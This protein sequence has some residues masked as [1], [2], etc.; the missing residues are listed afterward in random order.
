MSPSTSP[1]EPDGT[2][3]LPPVSV[4]L[5]VREEERHLTAAIEQV[6]DQDY[7]GELEIVVA[8]GPSHDRTREIAD[9]LAAG[10]AR[11]RVLDNP[12]GLTPAGLNIAVAAARHDVLV[13]VD[14][15]SEIE[16]DYVRVAVEALLE[17]GAANVGGLMV[18]V[19][20][21]PFEEAVARAMSSRLGIGAASFHTGGQA[22]PAPTVYLGVFRR[23]ALE[24]VGGYD[25]HFVRAQD[26]ELNHRLR[27][28]GDVVWFDP[29]LAVTYRPRGDVRSLAR[30]FFRSGQWRRQV[31][32]HHP[33]TAGVRYLT[34]PAAVVGIAG[35]AVL[36]LVGATVGPTWLVAGAVVPAAYAVGV[37]AGSVVVGR[38]MSPAARLRLP[39]AIATMHVAWGSGFLRGVGA[40][41][42]GTQ[43]RVLYPDP[44]N[45]SRQP[46]SA[47]GEGIDRHPAED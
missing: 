6:L 30:Q 2:S 34:P 27:E 36:G 37:L 44:A 32:R 35:G 15:H 8:V 3:S 10:D 39:A 5:T 14:G 23:D 20:T 18:P 17:T 46:R 38:G 13:R 33:E 26:W 11:V 25:E 41:A 16:R 22:G 24:R 43:A 9:D 4:F 47:A 28:N 12:T 1:S 29:R 31:M 42:G 7:P 19:G 21:T 45:A 40:E